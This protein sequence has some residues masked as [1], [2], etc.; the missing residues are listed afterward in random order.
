[1]QLRTLGTAGPTVSA[2]GLG[3][4]SLLTSNDDR[5]ARALLE[6]AL[7]AG[8][9]LV[10][11]ADV[12]G[13]GAVEEALGRLLGSRRD[14]VVLATKVGLPMGADP[15]RSGG[16]ARWITRAVEDSLRRLN[17]DHIDLYQ[18]H[19]PDPR[20]PID[21]TV[22]AFDGLRQSGKIRWAGS[23]VFPAEM[24][25]ESQWAAQRLGAAPFVS[26]QAPYSILVRG[27]ERAA[28][29]TAQ[30]HGVGVIAWG[31]LNGGWLTGK[32]RRGVA[33]PES[34]RA[35]SG[36]PFVR[37][38]DEAKLT[39]TERL[40]A[41]ADSAGMSLTAMSLGWAQE[42]PGISSVLIGPRTVDQLDDL[43]LAAETTLDPGVL[44]AIDEIIPPGTSLDPR[45][46]GWTP[47]ALAPDA[48]R[49]SAR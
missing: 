17:T 1:M 24:L 10:D 19:R 35:A 48:R 36:N 18:L 31:P 7:D 39:A 5:S 42:H 23:S 38:D 20:T 4:M 47:P 9:N 27:I 29:P 40:A 46:E 11:T 12:Y 45:N 22:A 34:S 6:R 8:I 43:L 3:T 41:V 25:V 2:I 33:V 16:S 30:A 14:E 15:E 21:E 28:L 26:E 32:Y 49:R 37:A 44:D 13:D